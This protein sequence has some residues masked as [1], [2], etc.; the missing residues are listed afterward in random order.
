MR[1]TLHLRAA[2]PYLLLLPGLLWLAVFYVYPAFQMFLVSLWTGNLDA[3]FSQTWNWGIYPEAITEYWPWLARSIVYGGLATALA[4][5]L[6]F[7]LAYAIAFRGGAYKNLLLFLVIAPFFTSFLLRTISWKIILAD[8]GFILGPIKAT[9]ILPEEFRLLATPAAVVFGITYNFQPF[10]TLPLYVALEKIDK[11]LIEAAEDLYAGPWRPHGMI[12]GLLIGGVLGFVVG[13]VMEYGPLTLALPFALAGALV[14][15]FLISQAFI[16]VTLP[17]AMPGI[18]AGSLLTFIPAVG[19]FVN[20]ELLGN[21]Q[22]LMIGNVIQARYL[23]VTDY[24]TA[25]ALSFVL[26]L[27]IIVGLL[28]YI[29]LLGT[30][31]LT[32]ASI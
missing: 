22:S 18:F 4:F 11:R 20:A 29:R 15:T 1:R 19:D 25:S 10:M 21:P 9:G 30:E 3:G 13:S 16:R 24:P 6:G 28:V 14:G 26:M 27:A 7:P 5:A 32:G 17:L 2:A 8:D 23:Q 31:E 12:V